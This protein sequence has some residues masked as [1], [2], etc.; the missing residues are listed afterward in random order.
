M[1]ALYFS[2]KDAN[3]LVNTI[4]F[5]WL[6]SLKDLVYL[7]VV[8]ND[9]IKGPKN[10]Y[11]EKGI[12]KGGIIPRLTSVTMKSILE[13]P[14]ACDFDSKKEKYNWVNNDFISN[15]KQNPNYPVVTK[16]VSTIKPLSISKLKIRPLIAG[17]TINS[18]FSRDRV[19]T[20]GAFFT[21]DD[22]LYSNDIFFIT[23]Y[24]NLFSYKK[25]AFDD[26]N[27]NPDLLIFQPNNDCLDYKNLI[28]SFF[29]GQYHDNNGIHDKTLDYAIVQLNIMA[30]EN[31]IYEIDIPNI[32]KKKVY[33][34]HSITSGFI[35]NKLK[36]S[37]QPMIKGIAK[38]KIGMR[39]KFHGS[40]TVISKSTE[41]RST[42]TMVKVQSTFDSKKELIFKNQI[43]FKN[44]SKPGDSGSV[45][46][47]DDNEIVGLLHAGDSE[48]V[49]IA[50]NI[51]DIFFDCH[52]QSS[53]SNELKIKD[54]LT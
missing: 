18:M 35:D 11:I 49:S 27:P 5:C 44:I 51:T 15:I 12:K 29:K 43:L 9:K 17:S 48:E 50:N 8:R 33:E 3:N 34:V 24:H 45:I 4:G 36:T 14:F 38:P 23:N 25:S 1:E 42:N 19:G 2:E 54:I 47:N 53:N 20:I 32:D 46:I 10:Y 41:I 31:T 37:S 22:T 7:S 40:T 30:L 26:Q 6:K 28:G 16:S 21:L 52:S 39:V 13:I